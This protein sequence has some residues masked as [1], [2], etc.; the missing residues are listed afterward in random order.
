MKKYLIYFAAFMWMMTACNEDENGFTDK[1]GFPKTSEENLDAT[2]VIKDFFS[3][4]ESGNPFENPDYQQWCG[5]SYRTTFECFHNLSEVRESKYAE[6]TDKL[7]PINWETQTLVICNIY[8]LT[9]LNEDYCSC[10]VY[11]RSG[12]YTIHVEI[13][14]SLYAIQTID[15]LGIAIVLDQKNVQKKDLKLI[16][17]QQKGKE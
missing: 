11:T 16:F 3:H 8:S 4:K 6:G 1:H 5:D 15:D 7:P 17:S 2:V 14:E 9:S 10:K 13:T 12:K